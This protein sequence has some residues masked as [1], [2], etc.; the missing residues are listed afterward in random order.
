MNIEFNDWGGDGKR[1]ILTVEN[2]IRYRLEMASASEGSVESAAAHAA[3]TASALGRLVELL[4][5][6]RVLTIGEVMAIAGKAWTTDAAAVT[7]NEVDFFPRL[8]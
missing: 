7:E 8:P 2:Y 5:V 4:L 3:T 6:N 1:K